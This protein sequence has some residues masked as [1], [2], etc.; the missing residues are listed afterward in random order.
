MHYYTTVWYTTQ[1]MVGREVRKKYA[2]CKPCKAL[3]LH[4]HARDRRS[5]GPLPYSAGKLFQV[6]R[7]F[8][9]QILNSLFLLRFCFSGSILFYRVIGVE[10]SR[11]RIVNGT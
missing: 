11:C 7:H 6:L 5:L 2:S 9:D 4:L 10:G 3:H 8:G 1:Y